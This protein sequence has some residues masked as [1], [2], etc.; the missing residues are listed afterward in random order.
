MQDKPSKTISR[1]PTGLPEV[2]QQL[3]VMQRSML[4]VD[5]QPVV[6]RP[7]YIAEEARLGNE[8][9]TGILEGFEDA[10]FWQTWAYGAAHWGERRLRHVLLR[11]GGEIVAAAQVIVIKIPLVGAGIAVVKSGPLWRL[12][13]RERNPQAFRRMLRA[14][15]EVYAVR[16]RLLLRVELD[17][18]EDETGALRAILSEEG[19]EQEGGVERTTVVDLSYSL[20][21]LRKSLKRQWK[22]NL[23]RAESNQLEI[24][25]GTDDKMTED[26]LRVHRDMQKIKGLRRI[27]DIRYLGYAQRSLAIQGKL[28]LVNANFRGKPVAGLVISS[29]GPKAL[30]VFAATGNKGRELR[31]SYLL[32]WRMLETLKARGFRWYDLGGVCQ[33]RA[34]LAGKL[35]REVECV[36][37]FHACRSTASRLLVKIGDRLRPSHETLKSLFG[38]AR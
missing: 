15:R 12:R 1:A 34:G 2:L 31:A 18:Y 11:Q 30:L 17:D 24:I 21:E 9:W 32:H 14:L 29:V 5:P 7:D 35:G 10:C 28:R 33:F 25:E 22:Q 6:E 26:F 36:G 37:Q 13:G 19:F 16:Q 4:A 8:V 38:Q 23:R 20:E 27:R 3:A